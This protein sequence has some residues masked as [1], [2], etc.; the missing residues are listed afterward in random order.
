MTT[1]EYMSLMKH[2]GA[3]VTD[4]GGILSHAAIMAR[5]FKVP[6][7][8]GTGNATKEFVDGDLIE[9]DSENG[10]ARKSI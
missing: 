3:I 4:L 6:C 1:P 10:F 8:V 9:V 7:L 5:E 2:A